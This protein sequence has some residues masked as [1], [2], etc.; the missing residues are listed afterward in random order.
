LQLGWPVAPDKADALVTG[1]K[2]LLVLAKTFLVS[3]LKPAVFKKQ[4]TPD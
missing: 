3:I 2:D 1:G 4:I